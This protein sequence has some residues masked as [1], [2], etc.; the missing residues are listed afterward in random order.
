MLKSALDSADARVIQMLMERDSAMLQHDELA[1]QLR[2]DNANLALAVSIAEAHVVNVVNKCSATQ[3]QYEQHAAYLQREIDKSIVHRTGDAIAIANCKR[4]LQTLAHSLLQ[5]KISARADDLNDTFL[6]LRGRRISALDSLVTITNEFESVSHLLSDLGR[7]HLL[8][9]FGMND[10]GFR[11]QRPQHIAKELARLGQTVVYVSP[12][13]CDT[14]SAGYSLKKIGCRLYELTFNCFLPL[15]IHAD[16]P[17]GRVVR[18]IVEGL[19]IFLAVA[20]RNGFAAVVQHPFWYPIVGTAMPSASLLVYDRFDN[21][22]GFPGVANSLILLED[23]LISNADVI[24]CSSERILLST[25]EI[26]TS[27]SFLVRNACGFSHFYLGDVALNSGSGKKIV[28]YFGAIEEWFDVALIEHLARKMPDVIFRLIGQDQ[29]D[30]AGQLGHF[31]NVEI[32]GEVPYDDLPMHLKDFDVCIIPFLL[33][34]LT[35]A[36]DPVKVYEYLSSGK[37]VV[38]TAL[39]ELSICSEIIY[40]AEGYEEFLG[41]VRR[42]ICESSSASVRSRRIDFARENSWAERAKSIKDI[43]DIFLCGHELA[44]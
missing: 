9:I 24:V 21:I 1:A 33:N 31:V 22:R 16:A 4:Q 20:V 2:R 13:F 26:S 42:A 44:K 30:L 14:Q 41:M 17:D 36:T 27:P 38:S 32:I 5:R 15:S 10:W 6:M 37:P 39:P 43:I 28:G 40:I 7:D 19:N 34:D 18:Q 3:I 11:T 29:I 35:N 23:R 25:R 12:S 8:F